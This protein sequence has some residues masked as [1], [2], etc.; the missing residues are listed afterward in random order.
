MQRQAVPL[1]YPHSPIVGT[2]MEARAALDSGALVTALRAETVQE[3]DASYI[4]LKADCEVHDFNRFDTYQLKKF[5]R[6][7]QDTCLNQKPLVSVG[8]IVK[9]GSV[10]ADGMATENGTLAL[11]FSATVAFVPWNGYNFED[12]IVVS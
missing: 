3:V 7:N 9:K 10:L 12:A 5:K 8:D 4:V 6:T 2:G 11:G 1:L